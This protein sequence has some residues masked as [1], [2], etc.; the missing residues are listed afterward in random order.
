MPNAISSQAHA[1]GQSTPI[2]IAGAGPVGLALALG[3]AHYGVRSIVLEKKAALSEHSKALLVATRTLE[4]FHQW[5]V[6]ERFC[7]AS[8]LL[9]Q[10]SVWIV[11]R[12]KPAATI[13]F[14][15]CLQDATPTPGVIVLP[16]SQTE[17][18]LL[19]AVRATGCVEVLFAHELQSFQQDE[20]G[21]RI[22]AASGGEQRSFRADFLVGCDGP[23]SAVRGQLGWKLEGKTYPSRLVIADVRLPAQCDALPWPRLAPLSRGVL[24]GIRFEN[25]SWRIIASLAPGESEDA[26]QSTPALARRVRQLFG[27]DEF[28]CVWSSVFHIHCR[29]SPHFR[30]G[31]VLLAGDAAHLN[32]PTGGQGMNAGIQDAHN[33]AWKLARIFQGGDTDA[34]LDSYEQERRGAVMGNVD[35]FTDL[36]TRVGFQTPPLLRSAVLRAV[37]LALTRRAVQCAAAPRMGMLNTRYGRSALLK[38]RGALVG[39]L[40]P[41]GEIENADGARQFLSELAA[42]QAVLLLFDDGRLPGWNRDEIAAALRAVPDLHILRLRPANAVLQS[43]DWRDTTGV[44]WRRWNITCAAAALLRPDGYIGWMAQRPTL[45]TLQSGVRSALGVK[46]LSQK[47]QTS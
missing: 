33:L 41:D 44:L 46:N 4:I 16:Q 32:S 20:D 1:G 45:A 9:S 38:N 42:Q 25:R 14:R 22:E 13:P 37:Q 31:R 40:A 6:F 5:K 36:L 8:P 18:L 43:G 39:S 35:R 28:A 47:T 7:A 11:G 29:T 2:L 24:A 30:S 26:A 12:K 34:L 19:E 21:V 10:I 15:H 3:L 23:R 27:T 17:S